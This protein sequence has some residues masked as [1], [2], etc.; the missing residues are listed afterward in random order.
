MDDCSDKVDKALKAH[1]WEHDRQVALASAEH[2]L[3]VTEAE[4]AAATVAVVA[5][6]V[7]TAP[8]LIEVAA[9]TLATWMATNVVLGSSLLV[10]ATVSGEELGRLS[11]D[12]DILERNLASAHKQTD[13]AA[14][15]AA[16]CLRQTRTG[17]GSQGGPG[18]RRPD[19]KCAS[20]EDVRR[21]RDH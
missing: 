7:V 13:E 11:Y 18:W 17:C 20:W 3:H 10:A 16:A 8:L 21:G 14:D 15:A 4:V 1:D 6:A 2:E 19:G 9:A 5:I 12:V